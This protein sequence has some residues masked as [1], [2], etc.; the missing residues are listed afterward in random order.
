MK[1]AVQASKEVKA[2]LQST[3]DAVVQKAK[4]SA[5]N[6]S[7]ALEHLRS[8][9]RSYVAFIPGASGYVDTT[10]DQLNELRESHG[11]E[12]D[13]VVKEITSDISRI[14]S[15]G[16][17]DF[18]T[19]AKVY[20]VLRN[21]VSKLQELGAKVG[22][23]LLEKNP[24]VKEKLGAGYDQL[25]SLA[26]KGGPQAMKVYEDVKSQ[27]SCKVCCIHFLTLYPVIQ[28]KELVQK[29]SLDN[30]SI[31]K[32]RK[33]LQDST[34]QLQEMA[35]ASGGSDMLRGAIGSLPRGNDVRI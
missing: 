1:K 20:D 13:S 25:K 26:E 5:N 8:I 31:E 35:K 24:Q 17:A 32:F 6:P 4:E 14:A 16:S 28:M 10:F 15:E 23:D 21:G 7:A 11:D 19:A 33:L 27:V 22:G 34:S 3:K 18:A 12:V 29:G 2:Y 30:E 9:T